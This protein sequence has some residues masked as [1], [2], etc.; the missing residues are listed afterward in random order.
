[1]AE[2]WEQLEGAKAFVEWFGRWP[3]FHDAE[4]VHL[5]LNR[6]ETS[7]LLVYA[8]E[9]TNDTDEKGYYKLAKHVLEEFI[10]EGIEELDLC[11]FSSSNYLMSLSVATK[12]GRIQISFTAA[13]GIG[14]SITADEVSLRFTPIPERPQDQ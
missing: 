8:F 2:T 9:M 6:L 10:L 12:E 11:G 13:W 3:S 4:V 7:S 5:H 14:G 1:M